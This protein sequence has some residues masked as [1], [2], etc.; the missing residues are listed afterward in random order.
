MWSGLLE[1]SIVDRCL[2][3]RMGKLQ[4]GRGVEHLGRPTWEGWDAQTGFAEW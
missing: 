4:R 2:G 1:D 3:Y